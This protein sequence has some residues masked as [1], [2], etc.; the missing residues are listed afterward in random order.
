MMVCKRSAG[1]TS[2][3]CGGLFKNFSQEQAGPADH[4][5]CTINI[6]YKSTGS[7]QFL[8]IAFLQFLVPKKKSPWQNQ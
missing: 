5:Y 2:E 3:V 8:L 7:L 6:V 1:Q 4:A